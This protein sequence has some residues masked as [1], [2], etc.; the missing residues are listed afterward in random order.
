M[1]HIRWTSELIL[2]Q[3]CDGPNTD[4]C[5]S[6]EYNNNSNPHLES[7]FHLQIIFISEISL[8][9]QNSPKT[10]ALLYYHSA[11]ELTEA[12]RA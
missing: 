5:P 11:D 8:N 12:Q 4:H 2:N 6:F 10:W 7:T 3:M 1:N 9:H